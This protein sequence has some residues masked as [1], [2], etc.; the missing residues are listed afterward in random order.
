M[1]GVRKE[2][3]DMR[4]KCGIDLV[5]T[6]VALLVILPIL[7]LFTGH[8]AAAEKKVF[9]W[10]FSSH[11]SPGSKALALCQLWWAEQVEKRSNG[12]IKVKMYWVDELCGP[13]EMMI[14][15]RNRLADVVG[16]V[17]SY[18]PGEAPI[19]NSTYLPFLCAPRVDQSVVIYNLLAKES[20]PFIDEMDKF[21]CVYGGAYD[22]PSY[23]LMGKKP[24]RNTDDFKGLRIRCSSDVGAIF[25]Q[26]GAA[27]MQV[28]VTEVYSALDTGLID[29]AAFSFLTFNAYKF[30][31]ISKYYISDLDISAGATMYYIN[32]D[33][34]NELPDNLK[35]V[36]QSVIDDSPAFMWD[37]ANLPD[38][39]N[40]ANRMIKQR[41]IEIIHF[42][43]AERAKLMAKAEEVWDSWAKRS[44]NYENAKR[45]LA[46]FVKI[47]DEVVAKY[48]Q[49]VPGIKYK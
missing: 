12:Q 11:A 19:W 7:S 32:K 34:W 44:G 35:K 30:D 21:N 8:V 14:A 45:A 17:P 26:F 38:R 42:P 22:C 39:T 48:P 9:N 4:K 33:A 15:V 1:I 43:K 23:N 5:V 25:K 31:E 27:P 3:R 24:L 36:V 49:G 10:K 37:F 41:N 18:T 16:N 28:P 29:L 2:G 47:R 46:D 40:E 20:K 13:K 6:G